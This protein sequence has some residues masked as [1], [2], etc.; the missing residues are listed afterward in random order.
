MIFSL[1]IKMGQNGKY[2]RYMNC[3]TATGVTMLQ[4]DS[5]DVHYSQKL[6][7]TSLLLCHCSLFHTTLFS[8]VIN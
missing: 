5:S 7:I 6:K 3:S 2:Y 4:Y 8:L 1:Q